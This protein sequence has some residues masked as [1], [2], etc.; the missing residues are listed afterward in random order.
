MFLAGF[1]KT[2]GI[3]HFEQAPLKHKM[4]AQFQVQKLKKS[5]KNFKVKKN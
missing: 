4:F 3:T 1:G 5:M 2:W